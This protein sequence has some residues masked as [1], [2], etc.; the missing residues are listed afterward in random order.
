MIWTDL[1]LNE[2]RLVKSSASELGLN[3]HL[4]STVSFESLRLGNL[5]KRA[6]LSGKLMM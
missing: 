1:N 3:N 6:K 5:D 2:I 4:L